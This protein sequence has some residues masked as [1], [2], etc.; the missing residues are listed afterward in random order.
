MKRTLIAFWL[1]V[2]CLPAPLFAQKAIVLVRHGERVDESED[3]ALSP[4][5]IARAARL[6]E[7]LK[8][9]GVTA[10]FATE[11]VRTFET[12]KPLADRLKLT[13]ERIPAADSA[14][15]VTTLRSAHARDVVLV[16]AHSNT[17]PD[18]MTR[19]GCTESVEIAT[20][21]FDNLFV[22]VPRGRGAPVVTRL[23]Y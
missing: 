1:V 6:A 10:V 22:I 14:R 17:I 8:D 2:I 21:E 13:I 16:A 11:F 23:R 5:G 20:T 9:A 12:A 18:I 15:L 3:A 19:L 4:A 7:M